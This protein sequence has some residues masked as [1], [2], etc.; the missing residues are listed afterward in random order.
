MAIADA[1]EQTQPRVTLAAHELVRG[2]S[3]DIFGVMEALAY[4]PEFLLLEAP[5][6]FIESLKFL[7]EHRK[8]L[9]TKKGKLKMKEAVKV[10]E[11]WLA[12]VMANGAQAGM[13]F[14]SL[15]TFWPS[16]LKNFKQFYRAAVDGIFKPLEI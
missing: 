9:K 4:V 12:M 1:V 6:Q 10:L 16:V 8:K 15:W 14:A 2:I 13:N 11:D 7:A 5:N 3:E